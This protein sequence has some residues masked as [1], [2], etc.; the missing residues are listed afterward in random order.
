MIGNP[1]N[2]SGPKFLG[3]YC[4]YSL[5]VLFFVSW[6]NKQRESQWSMPKLNLA[7]PYEIA[8]LRGGE[9]EALRIATFSLIDRGLIEP[10]GVEFKTKGK[11][12][13]EHARRPIEKAILI[14]LLPGAQIKDIYTDVL[15]KS[16]CLDY[17]TSL[18]K[19]RLIRT[20]AVLESRKSLYFLGIFMIAGLAGMKILVALQRGRSNITFLFT[21][22]A[23]F[24][25]FLN[26][27]HNT[28]LTGLGSRALA[29]LNTLFR[30]LRDRRLT[31][32]P[33]GQTNEAALLAAVY[34]ASALSPVSFPYTKEL[35]PK[36]KKK[37]WFSSESSCGSSCGTSCGSSCGSSCGGG[38][39]C[40]GCGGD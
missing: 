7:D 8:F 31:L 30:G 17:Q 5:L 38:G 32:K 40:G 37:S 18:E 14:K 13:I 1:L 27:I 4:V 10:L 28:E 34:G 22:C 36:A 2:F 23:I 33:G 9:V 29:D 3:F 16:T 26:K 39:G 20:D 11:E 12:A 19:Y 24:L 15:L 25:I 6:R 35:F 21:L